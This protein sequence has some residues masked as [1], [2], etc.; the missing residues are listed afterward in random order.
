[1]LEFVLSIGFDVG[2]DVGFVVDVKRSR[3]SSSII[4]FIFVVKFVDGKYIVDEF[5]VMCDVL[6]V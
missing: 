3:L 4:D 1:M 5:K 2:F 6:I